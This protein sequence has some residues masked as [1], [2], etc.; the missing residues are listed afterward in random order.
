MP[1][2]VV[3]YVTRWCP[4][5]ARSRRVLQRS[6]VAFQEIDIESCPE[7]ETEMRALNGNSG[8]VPTIIIEHGGE[9][10]ALV[11]PS[12]SALSDALRPCKS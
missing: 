10:I 5:C 6:G 12:D 7:A 1:V 2:M 9:R 3:A 11:E 4:D 8:K